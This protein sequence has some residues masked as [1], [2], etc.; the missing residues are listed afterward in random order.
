MLKENASIYSAKSQKV[1]DG[2]LLDLS[3]CHLDFNVEKQAYSFK[4]SK[5]CKILLPISDKNLILWIVKVW[6]N[7]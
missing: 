7:L 4:E 6:Q 3:G 5:F 2:C 1:Q